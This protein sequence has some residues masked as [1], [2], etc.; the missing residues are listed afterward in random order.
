MLLD[1]DQG[2][3]WV[4]L[5]GLSLFAFLEALWP[6][7][8]RL[9]PRALRWL[10][11]GTLAAANT[12]LMR[13]LVFVPLLLWAVWL[14][15]QGW[16]LVRA[17]GLVGVPELIF[18]VLIL[19][20]FDYL[21]HRANHRVAFLWRFHKVHHSDRALDVT[22]ALRFHPGE[23]LLSGIAK[24]FWLAVLGPTPVAWFLFEAL[25][26]ASA[27]FHHADLR[28][29]PRLERALRWLWVTPAFHGA[30]HLVDRRWGDRNFSTLVPVWDWLFRSFA[31]PPGPLD[32][33]GEPWVF[34]LPEGRG[35]ADRPLALLLDPFRGLNQRGMRHVG[36]LHR[37]QE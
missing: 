18:S 8:R 16:G 34:G 11:H 28:L 17:I 32:E 10:R 9:G 15:E 2:R 14:E 23:L 19:D 29:A 13:S 1:L 6:A 4:F 5:I 22:T 12:V 36:P 3:L 31:A 35:D 20:A 7:G 24:A 21:W 25:V 27:Q 26:S 37:S 33:R 30:H